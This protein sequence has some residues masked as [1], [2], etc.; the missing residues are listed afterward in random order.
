MKYYKSVLGLRLGWN[1]VNWCF[2]FY[3]RPQTKFGEG[4]AFT[5]ICL[6]A[7]RKG[8]YVTSHASLDRSHDR[9]PLRHQTWNLPTSFQTSDLRSTSFPSL[10]SPPQQQVWDLPPPSRHQT[11][12]LP[13]FPPQKSDLGPTPCPCYWHLVVITR[14]RLKLVYLRI[15]RPYYYWHLVVSTEIR[16]VDKREIRIV[17]EC[18]LVNDRKGSCGKVLF[19]HLSVI[20]SMEV[21]WCHFL[22]G[23]LVPCSFWGCTPE[24]HTSSRTRGGQWSGRYASSNAFFFYL[25]VQKYVSHYGAID[26]AFISFIDVNNVFEQEILNANKMYYLQSVQKW[27]LQIVDIYKMKVKPFS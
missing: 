16:M 10:P 7:E 1:I 22:Y 14:D 27:I 3:Y 4:N 17:V 6:F 26:F 2:T 9:V 20:L 8:R 19:L 23:F 21:C 15:Y 18:C 5:G 11:W 24:T 12:D 13:H 25:C